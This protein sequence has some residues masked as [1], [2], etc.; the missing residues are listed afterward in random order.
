MG[1][2]FTKKLIRKILNDLANSSEVSEDQEITVHFSLSHY[3]VNQMLKFLVTTDAQNSRNTQSVI[4]DKISFVDVNLNSPLSL[5]L[6][7][8]VPDRN[9]LSIIAM[10]FLM[11][12]CICLT[13]RL[14]VS[15]ISRH[16]WKPPFLL[17]F[18]YEFTQTYLRMYNEETAKRLTHLEREAISCDKE[19]NFRRSI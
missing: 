14:L 17:F 13:L 16:S 12:V 1:S 5:H 18:L 9:N 7:F 8:F 4:I 11:S 10:L 15:S 2:P 6:G 19:E 3:E